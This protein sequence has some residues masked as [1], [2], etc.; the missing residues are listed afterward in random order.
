MWCGVDIIEIRL[1][2]TSATHLSTRRWQE[3]L[4]HRV[5]LK[6]ETKISLSLEITFEKSTFVLIPIMI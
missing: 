6:I 4:S 5:F 1:L 3:M 2:G